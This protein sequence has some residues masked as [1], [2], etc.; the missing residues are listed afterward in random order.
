[1]VIYTGSGNE[2]ICPNCGTKIGYGPVLRWIVSGNTVRIIDGYCPNNGCPAY[3]PLSTVP[4]CKSAVR[5]KTW[6]YAKSRE[7]IN[8][9]DGW[10]G[11]LPSDSYDRCPKHGLELMYR[12]SAVVGNKQMVEG[13]C[14]IPDCDFKIDVPKKHLKRY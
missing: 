5:F 14:T 12:G 7:I 3:K 4:G 13:C 8:I 9:K 6:R 1:M 10:G 2:T 11:N